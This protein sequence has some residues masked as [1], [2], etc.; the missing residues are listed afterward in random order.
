MFQS[1][2]VLSS[3]SSTVLSSV[4]RQIWRCPTKS[5][6]LSICSPITAFSVPVRGNKCYSL[7]RNIEISMG[8]FSIS[9]NT[10]SEH[11]NSM[12]TIVDLSQYH[13]SMRAH[14]SQNIEI[15]VGIFVDLSQYHVEISMRAHVSR[16]IE[17]SVGIFVDLS[18]YHIEISMSTLVDLSQYYIGTLKFQWAHWWI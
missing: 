18:Q 7:H 14:V 8:T 13:V 1:S 10:K 3:P 2:P 9:G 15:S 4:L 12:G 11:W 16:N 5:A 6:F 17:I